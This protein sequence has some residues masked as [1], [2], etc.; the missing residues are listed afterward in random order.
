MSG[1]ADT[2]GVLPF[3]YLTVWHVFDMD[4]FTLPRE[5]DY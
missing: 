3:M 4:I 2:G 1:K 5:Q